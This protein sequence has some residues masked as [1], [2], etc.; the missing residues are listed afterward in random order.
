MSNAY[1]FAIVGT[2]D[3]PLYEAEFGLAVK[4]NSLG[5]KKEETK[6]LNQFIAHSALD[7]IDE[8][9]WT[10]TELYFKNIDRYNEMSVSCFV[11][12]SNARLILLHETKADDGIKTFFNECHELLIKT[13]CNPF[14]DANQPIASVA[15]D[16][17]VKSLAKRHL[18]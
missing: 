17:R 5:N 2:N 14:H 13:I 8:A 4:D 15:F 1:Y 18:P 16:T 3:A 11:T 12:P 9:V 10:T 6:Y 7:I